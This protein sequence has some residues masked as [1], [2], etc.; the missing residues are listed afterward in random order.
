MSI[1]DTLG[2][3]RAKADAAAG[4]YYQADAAYWA[5]RDVFRV[6]AEQHPEAWRA[7]PE[8]VKSDLVAAVDDYDRK[9]KTRHA[10]AKAAGA[11]YEAIAGASED[12][13]GVTA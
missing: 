12:P 3:L 1:Y 2:S 11:A 9:S 7:L 5:A 13:A 6:L 8:D 4:R 10:T